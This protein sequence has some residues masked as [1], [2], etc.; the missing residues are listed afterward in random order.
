MV[1]ER[2]RFLFMSCGESQTNERV[3]EQ[4]SLWFSTTSEW[5]S[6]TRTNHEVICL[7][8]K[9]WDITTIRFLWKDLVQIFFAV[10]KNTFE[11]SWIN[12]LKLK[13][14]ESLIKIRTLKYSPRHFQTLY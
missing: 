11:L 13:V 7:L 5:K 8:Y 4:V 1:G 6:Y 2:V 10:E 9:H 12:S 3:F 14:R